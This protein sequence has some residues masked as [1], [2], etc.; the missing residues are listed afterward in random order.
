MRVLARDDERPFVRVR[1]P[2]ELDPAPI[3]K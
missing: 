3:V 2:E 1:Q